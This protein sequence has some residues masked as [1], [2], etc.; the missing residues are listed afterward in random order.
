VDQLAMVITTKT[1]PG[2]RDEV[3]A[4]YEQ[5]LAPRAEANP[6][7]R[8]VV[9]CDAADDPDTFVLFELYATREAFEANAAQP[10]FREYMA[11]AGPLLAAQPEITMGTPRW[12]TGV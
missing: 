7:Q 2:K 10:W 6:D 1:Q 9:W 5:H 11:A 12:A 3:R 4:L 8:V